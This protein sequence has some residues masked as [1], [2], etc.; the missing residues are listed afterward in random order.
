MEA[1]VKLR[2]VET[3][4]DGVFVVGLAHSPQLLTEALAQARA[5][6]GKAAIPLAKGFVEVPPII[7]S[8]EEG[9]CIGCA[10]CVEVC[11]FS[12]IEMVKVDKRRKA[13]VIK[14]ACKGCGICASHCPVFA[15][16]VGGFTGD[17][18]LEQV[19]GF[20][21]EEGE[22]LEEGEEKVSKVL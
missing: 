12:A 8:V 17:A 10:I 11:P 2:P 7:A 5:G 1:H 6:S 18:I 20:K 22:A 14:A 4:T 3:A 9:K 19:R 15:I 16:D 21:R 13:Q